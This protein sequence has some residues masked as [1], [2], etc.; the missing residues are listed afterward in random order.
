VF[1][2]PKL[3]EQALAMVMCAILLI[4]IIISIV[5]YETYYSQQINTAKQRK[6]LD[7]N[8]HEK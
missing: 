5:A 7:G 2:I 8:E 4:R 6:L 3:P 1:I